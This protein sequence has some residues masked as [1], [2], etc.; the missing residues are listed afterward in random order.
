MVA[1]AAVGSSLDP[2]VDDLSGYS[3]TQAD[4]ASAR[5]FLNELQNAFT[6]ASPSGLPDQVVTAIRSRPDLAAKIAAEAVR[7]IV[8][9]GGSGDGESCAAI[10]QVVTAAIDTQREYAVA[11]T[12]R[13]VAAA[14]NYRA[15]IVSAAT[16]QAKDLRLAFE[17]A[18]RQ[19]VLMHAV[20]ARLADRN[21]DLT[22]GGAGTINP[23]NV[24]GNGQTVRS[25]EQP[26]NNNNPPNNP[27]KGNPP[28]GNPPNNPP[29]D[30]G[31]FLGQPP[32]LP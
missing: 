7:V 5:A 32:R 13:T 30:T 9:T 17:R 11:I 3:I 29:R 31:S 6:Q 22:A 1:R 10:E 20:L 26:P 12:R 25:P 28:R 16:A 2:A 19:G 8:R 23:G 18:G 24:S 21:G 14:P 27:P 15:C 4:Q